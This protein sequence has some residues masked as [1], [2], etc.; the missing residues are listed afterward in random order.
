MVIE[1]YEAVVDGFRW[2]CRLFLLLVTTPLD[3]RQLRP[4]RLWAVAQ[5]ACF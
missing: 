4:H 2:T 5:Q 1:F 3:H